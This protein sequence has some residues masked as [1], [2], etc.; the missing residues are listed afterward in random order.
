MAIESVSEGAM[1][2][3]ENDSG[4]LERLKLAY[5]A[6]LDVDVLIRMLSK[7]HKIIRDDME[8]EVLLTAS[9]RHLLALN[10]V[11]IAVLLGDNND[12]TTEELREVIHG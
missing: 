6:S 7:Q 5:E 1:L 12:T 8:L 2:P 4:K 9:L 10:G 11:V 3:P